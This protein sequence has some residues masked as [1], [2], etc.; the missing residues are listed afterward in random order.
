[1]K[2][3]RYLAISESGSVRLSVGKPKLS[4]EEIMI[5]LKLDVPSS[6]FESHAKLNV[7]INDSTPPPKHIE[8]DV[9]DRGTW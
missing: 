1:M 9:S 8:V 3:N 7:K 6:L 2:L 5:E 4:S